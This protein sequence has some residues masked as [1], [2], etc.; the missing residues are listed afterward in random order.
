MRNGFAAL[1]AILL[2]PA[3]AFASDEPVN[4]APA[5]APVQEV[6]RVVSPE[7]ANRIEEGPVE[8]EA[9]SLQSTPVTET[10]EHRAEM[11]TDAGLGQPAGPITAAERSKLEMARAAIEASRAAGTLF[12]TE[13]PDDTIPATEAE[14]QAMKMQQLAARGSTPPAADPVAGIGSS[15]PSIQEVGPSGLTEYEEAKLRGE[16]PAPPI[17]QDATPTEETR[18]GDGATSSDENTSAAKKESSNE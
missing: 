12:V 8:L 2:A 13:L 17:R 4:Q 16:H 11:F 7:V 10:A 14:L 9:S 6:E 15:L 18:A 5:N 1:S 3:W